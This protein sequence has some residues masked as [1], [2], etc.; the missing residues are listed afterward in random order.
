KNEIAELEDEQFEQ[1]ESMLKESE[2]LAKDI[3]ND[4]QNLRIKNMDT[5]V[6]EWE[7]KQMINEIM[8]K[9]NKLEQVYNRI[10]EENKLLNN[11]M[12]SFNKKN[13]ELIEKQKQIEAL[14]E[15]VFTDELKSLL[16][17]FQKLAEKFDSRKLNQ[18]SDKM[19]YTY[20][21]LQKQLDRNLEMLKKMK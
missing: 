6:S 18:L 20:E 17:E 8:L 14:L 7:K 1:I 3:Q 13:E 15:E 10:K 5:N 9:Q 19:D 11:Y 21:D 16:E 2:Q 12:Q 4:L